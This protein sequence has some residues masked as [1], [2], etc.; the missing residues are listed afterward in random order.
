MLLYFF[1]QK[2]VDPVNLTLTQLLKVWAN[3]TLNHIQK[4]NLPLTC[5]HWCIYL[6]YPFLHRHYEVIQ[7][8]CIRWT[9]LSSIPVCFYQQEELVGNWKYAQMGGTLLCPA[10]T[11]TTFFVMPN[12]QIRYGLLTKLCPYL[13]QFKVT[14][15]WQKSNL[16]VLNGV[17]RYTLPW[18]K[19]REVSIVNIINA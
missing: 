14:S 3:I 9:F 5:R 7:K 10:P 19:G 4:M 8:L 11:A 18:V 6:G 2:I 15:W 16:C 17:P 13:N 12:T 1:Y